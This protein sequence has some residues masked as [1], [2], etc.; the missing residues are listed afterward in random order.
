MFRPPPGSTR[1]ATLFPYTPLFAS[2]PGSAGWSDEA[3]AATPKI[4]ALL[5]AAAVEAEPASLVTLTS[6][7]VCLVYGRDEQ[8]IEAGK[9]LA[10]RL[11]VT[12][13]L[14]ETGQIIATQVMDVPVFTGPTSSEERRV[15]KSG[16]STCKT[17]L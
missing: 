2:L 5:A 14:S 8:A 10:G 16:V 17:R 7:G 4:A 12:V 6:Q 15:G 3:A 13:L 11:D 1:P 9:Q